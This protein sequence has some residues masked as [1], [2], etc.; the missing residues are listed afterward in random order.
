LPPDWSYQAGVNY[1]IGDYSAYLKELYDTMLDRST[2][3]TQAA[4]LARQITSGSKTRLEA[5][6]AIRDY[7]SRSIRQ[8]GPSFTDLPLHELS[9]ADVT[10]Q[11]GYG[12]WA[13]RAILLHAMLKAAGFAPEFV[14]AS[15]LPSIPELG[16]TAQTFP[17]PR[18]FSSPLVKVSV[19]GQA[20][21]LNETDA[22]QY[23]RM[24]SSSH[25]GEL[26]LL[27]G[28]QTYEVIQ[29]APGAETRLETNRILS[30]S[31]NGRVR[32]SYTHRY[33][34]SNY[35]TKKQFY[36]ELPPEERRRQ[37]QKLVSNV[38]QGARPVGDLITDFKGYPGVEKYTVEVDNYAVVDGKYMYFDLPYTVSLFAAGSDRRAL[39]MYV[40]EKTETTLRTEINLPPGF[41]Q[42]VIA[43][44]N[45]T[46]E[47]PPHAGRAEVTVETAGSK[48][49]IVDQLRTWPAIVSAEDYPS[50][51]KVNAVLGKKSS[52]VFLLEKSQ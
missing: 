25:E 18:S 42:V 23:A 37:Y 41:P 22:E 13:D 2:Q 44:E 39:P 51:L 27:L 15:S 14:L 10:L 16:E 36:A 34:G 12:H 26:G 46:V 40:P 52:K 11:D 48:S 19:E 32:I 43:P 45:A 30:L 29:A 21:Y 4:A 50:V 33:Y 17:L 9:A 38:A 47:V 31:D 24:G 7:L 3:S 1:F 8:A 28:S 20:Y 6:I 49:V 35:G 5:V